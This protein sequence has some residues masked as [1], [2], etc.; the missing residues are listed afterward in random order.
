[1][2]RRTEREIFTAPEKEQSIQDFWGNVVEILDETD[3]EKL[4]ERLLKRVEKFPQLSSIDSLASIKRGIQFTEK[5]HYGQP[6][7]FTDMPYTN[8]P[9]QVTLLGLELMDP[10]HISADSITT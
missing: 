7:K 9:L 10:S 2:A 5:A 4:K 3:T 6:R 1:M 8:H